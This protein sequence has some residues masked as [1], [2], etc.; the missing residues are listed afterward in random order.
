MRIYT[1]VY[2]YVYIYIHIYIFAIFYSLS[3]VVLYSFFKW[4]QTCINIYIYICFHSSTIFDI[5]HSI[6]YQLFY[7]TLTYI[8]FRYSI[9]QHLDI[10]FVQNF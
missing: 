10:Y 5:G 4:N 9:Y 7:S 2:I 3:N 6:V 1:Y 8:F